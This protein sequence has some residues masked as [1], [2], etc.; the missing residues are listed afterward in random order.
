[1]QKSLN[2]FEKNKENCPF[3][4]FENEQFLVFNVKRII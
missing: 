1:L 4:F 3:V 2:F